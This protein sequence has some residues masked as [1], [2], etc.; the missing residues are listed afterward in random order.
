MSASS[1]TVKQGFLRL[2]SDYESS[3]DIQLTQ[4]KAGRLDWQLDDPR[5]GL[6][7]VLIWM[8]MVNQSSG[9]LKTRGETRWC[10]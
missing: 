10:R 9:E 5:N 3:M 1:A 4:D 2:M 6:D 7:G 8:K